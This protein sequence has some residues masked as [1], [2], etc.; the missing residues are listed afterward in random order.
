MAILIMAAPENSKYR[1]QV[2]PAG[3]LERD[4]EISRITG[5]LTWKQS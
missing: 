5:R 1:V 2:T 4:L 3:I